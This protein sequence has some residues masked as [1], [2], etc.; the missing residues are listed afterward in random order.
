MTRGLTAKTVEALKPQDKRYEVRDSAVPGLVLRINSDGTKTWSV[1]VSRAGR[2]Q[3]VSL[4]RYPALSLKD[5][6]FVASERKVSVIKT[7]GTPEPVC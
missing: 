6:R 1:V 4:G 2:R 7:F 3:R 5:A